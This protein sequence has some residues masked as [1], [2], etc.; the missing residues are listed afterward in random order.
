MTI[1]LKFKETDQIHFLHNDKYCKSVV[2]GFKIERKPIKLQGQ[3]G[4]ITYTTE[5]IY[6]CNDDDNEMNVFIKISSEKAFSSKEALIQS[7]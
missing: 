2:R 6:L 7:L 4:P 5:T 1:E 3:N